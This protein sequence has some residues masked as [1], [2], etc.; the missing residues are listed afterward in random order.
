MDTKLINRV[1]ASSIMI[2]NLEDHYPTAMIHTIDLH[3]YL[4]QGM[5]LREKDFRA[6]LK[7]TDWTMYQDAYAVLYC[8]T[9]AIIPTW[10]YMLLSAQLEGVNC[11]AYHCTKDEFL[12]RYYQEALS[13]IDWSVFQDQRVVVKGCSTRDVPVSA[14]VE[15]TRQLRT[16]AQSVMFGEPCSTVPVFKRPRKI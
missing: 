11:Q 14:Y 9:D 4:F 6:A 7:E 5:I 15:A 10:A 1:A 3:D 16:R 12:N 8:R 13:H 2:L